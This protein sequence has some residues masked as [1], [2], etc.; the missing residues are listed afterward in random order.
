MDQHTFVQERLAHYE[1]QGLTPEPGGE[2]Q[3]AHYPHPKG[4]GDKTVW[5]LHNDHQV[6]G[7]L[8]SEECGQ[9]CFFSGDVKEFLDN[10]WCPDWFELYSL[11]E[12]W[13]S[14]NGKKN[15]KLL[16]NHP[17]RKEWNSRGAEAMNNHPNTKKGRVKG[18]EKTAQQQ[19]KPV[20]CLE[21]G[22]VY[23][24]TREASR[25]TNVRQSSISQSCRK[26]CKAGG[27]RWIYPG[28]VSHT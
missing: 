12:K 18:G 19:S 15:V 25:K 8:Q 27:F 1:E 4:A 24:S 14:E 22:I 7:L 6:Q 26:G 16:I 20:I 21:T 3:E 28:T 11:Y 9:M 17:S 13:S 10:N 23:Q 5:L 2:W